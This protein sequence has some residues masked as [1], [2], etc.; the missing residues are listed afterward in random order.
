M[1]SRLETLKTAF[2][3]NSQDPFIRYALALE[4]K[5]ASDTDSSRK[6][7]E[8]LAQL[9]PDYVPQ[10]Y[11]FAQLLETLN[12][13]ELALTVYDK[14][15]AKAQEHNELHALSELKAAKELLQATL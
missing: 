10:Y 4:Y 14:G 2:A 11:H 13:E 7:F 1:N 15:I 8:E 6:C 12:E 5:E 3:N 9:F